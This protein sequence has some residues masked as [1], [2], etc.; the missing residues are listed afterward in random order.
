MELKPDYCNC[1]GVAHSDSWSFDSAVCLS[2]SKNVNKAVVAS[3]MNQN[4]CNQL[5]HCNFW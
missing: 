2:L 4:L 5:P 1:K 3:L